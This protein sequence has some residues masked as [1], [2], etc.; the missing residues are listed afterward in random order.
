MR[1][2]DLALLRTFVAVSERQSMTAAATALNFTQSA[3][4]QQISRLEDMMGIQVF[5][6]S[7]R[8]LALTNAGEKLLFRARELLAINDDLLS[9]P[10]ADGFSGIVRL[11]VCFDLLSAGIATLIRDYSLLRPNVEVALVCASS[12]SLERQIAEKD[13]D[14]AVLQEMPEKA[15]GSVLG[16]DQLVWAGAAAGGAFAKRPLPLSLVSVDC[17]FRQPVLEALANEGVEW[18]S[19]FENGGYEATAATVQ[20]DLAVSAWLTSAIPLGLEAVQD[21][22]NLPKLPSFTIS[23]FKREGDL[24]SI[25]LD[26]AEHIRT[27]FVIHTGTTM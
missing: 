15:R 23:L 18:R 19:V 12:A 11:G 6:R 26:L 25:A 2:I 14:I 10:D 1:H 21:C 24:P 7:S 13:L 20:A 22:E 5:A 16:I 8:R 3:V 4:S 9:D 27:Q 17:I